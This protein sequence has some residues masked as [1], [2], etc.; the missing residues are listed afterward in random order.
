[1]RLKSIS[2]KFNSIIAYDFS[3]D[4]SGDNIEF[5][6]EILKE[7]HALPRLISLYSRSSP[8]VLFEFTNQGAFSLGRGDFSAMASRMKEFL[9]IKNEDRKRFRGSTIVYGFSENIAGLDFELTKDIMKRAF[10]YDSTKK[11]DILFPDVVAPTPV[12]T[13][14]N[15]VVLHEDEEK[16]IGYLFENTYGYNCRFVLDKTGLILFSTAYTNA[17]LFEKLYERIVEHLDEDVKVIKDPEVEEYESFAQNPLHLLLNYPLISKEKLKT[18]LIDIGI[19]FASL[20]Y[21]EN[22]HTLQKRKLEG[23]LTYFTNKMKY[24]IPEKEISFPIR[25]EMVNLLKQQGLFSQKSRDL[26]TLD[27]IPGQMTQIKNY[28]DKLSIL[29]RNIPTFHEK[30]TMI[31]EEQSKLDEF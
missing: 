29:D 6:Y 1:M 17:L 31:H 19:Q 4:V 28:F 16:M 23:N 10:I 9:S 15:G 24:F 13:F 27:L 11:E 14:F 18:I 5:I 20:C 12:H 26:M 21:E 8:G 7:K 30:T 3:C 25:A 22:R 2:Q